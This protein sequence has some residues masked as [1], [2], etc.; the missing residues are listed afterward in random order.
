MAV[1]RQIPIIKSIKE[2]HSLPMKER[3][4]KRMTKK[5]R[6]NL[7]FRMRYADKCQ[8]DTLVIMLPTTP[9]PEFIRWKTCWAKTYS[10]QGFKH[11]EVWEAICYQLM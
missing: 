11:A 10:K 6:R 2:P 3:G 1:T 7:T 8:G 5:G 9:I 4:E